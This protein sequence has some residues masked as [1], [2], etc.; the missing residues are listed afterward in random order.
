MPLPSS[1]PAEVFRAQAG[2][3]PGLGA[4]W[5]MFGAQAVPCQGSEV[6]KV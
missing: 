1:A 4:S 3:L 6:G 2:A 5:E